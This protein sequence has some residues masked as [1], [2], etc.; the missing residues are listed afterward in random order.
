MTNGK[1]VAVTGAASGLGEAC[2]ALMAE[3]GATVVGVDRVVGTPLPGGS[4]DVVDLSEVEAI[5][6]VDRWVERHGRVDGL[7][8]AA[9]IM[10]TGNFAEVAPSD[11]DRVFAINVRAAFF[12]LQAVAPVMEEAGQGSVVLFSSTAGR[13]G[14]P[15]AAAYAASKAANWSIVQ[16]ASLAYAEAG[17]RVNAVSPGLI[18]TPMLEGIR[19]ART[20]LGAPSPEAVREEWESRVPL[21]RLGSPAEVAAL[22]AFLI[23]DA[24]SYITG[25]DIGVHGGM[26]SS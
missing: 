6:A 16:S 25:E 11:F 10:H 8:N 12:L 13:I 24:S 5:P 21:G 18:E 1:V 9:G 19:V 4:W 23:S 20:E 26:L 2:A 7:V 15:L 22:V 3:R 17:I 14:R